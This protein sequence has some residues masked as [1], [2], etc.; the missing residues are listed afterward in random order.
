MLI[1]YSIILLLCKNHCLSKIHKIKVNLNWVVETKV[2]IVLCYYI[3]LGAVVLSIFTTALLRININEL[4]SYFSCEAKGLPPPNANS[5]G[6]EKQLKSI[7]SS[8][9]PILISLAIVILGFLP[10]VNLVYVIKFSELKS[11]I[12]TYSQTRYVHYVQK[13]AEKSA[14]SRYVPYN[15]HRDTTLQCD[16]MTLHDNTF[17]TEPLLTSQMNNDLRN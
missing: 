15:Q 16:S 8:D 10:V 9:N 7:S 5:S 14:A 4:K 2:L 3:L 1:W 11:K 6:C 13:E 17:H 12:K